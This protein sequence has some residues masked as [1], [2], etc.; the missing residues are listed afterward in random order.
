MNNH[1][2]EPPRPVGEVGRSG[3]SLMWA[4]IV[5]IAA[6]GT[7]VIVCMCATGCGA[8]QAAEDMAIL[9]QRMDDMEEARDYD[10]QVSAEQSKQVAEAKD[11]LVGL[12]SVLQR[13]ADRLERLEA[14]ND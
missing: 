11:A 4:R 14:S 13:I 6:F 3:R 9:Q 5:G 1:I 7:L 2:S 10:R 12:A 8:T